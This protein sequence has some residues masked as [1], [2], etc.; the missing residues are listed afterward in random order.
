MN[1]LTI[2]GW[3]THTLDN[4]LEKLDTPYSETTLLIDNKEIYIKGGINVVK[5]LV[6]LIRLNVKSETSI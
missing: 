2:K 3:S 5:E 6:S 1:S 4:N